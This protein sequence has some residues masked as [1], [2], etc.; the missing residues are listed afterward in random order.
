MSHTLDERK[1]KGDFLDDFNTY[2]SESGVA[3]QYEFITHRLTESRGLLSNVLHNAI[4]AHLQTQHGLVPLL[5]YPDGTTYLA[6]R[7]HIPH[8]IGADQRAA[9]K[10][11]RANNQR[12]LAGQ[13]P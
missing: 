8:L 3:E 4:A 13:I 6:K 11:S 12:I 1:H 10:K 2:L 5:F 7:G 9:A